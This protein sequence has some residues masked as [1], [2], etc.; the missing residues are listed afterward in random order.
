M[1]PGFN[2]K[3]AQG[4]ETSNVQTSNFQSNLK[5]MA[6]AFFQFIKDAILELLFTLF[7]TVV[8]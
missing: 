7:L 3:R 1:K 5:I 2:Y 4:D 8:L 6:F